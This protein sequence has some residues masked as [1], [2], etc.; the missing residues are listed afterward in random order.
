[1]N[2]QKFSRLVLS[3]IITA[4]LFSCTS[5]N[6]ESKAQILYNSHCAG[7]HV[8]PSIEDLPKTIWENGVLPDMAARMGIIDS[9]NNPLK[10]KL[11]LEQGLF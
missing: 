3:L 8:L 2:K 9:S 1:M 4:Q 10:R 6:N 7:C 5:K 11:L